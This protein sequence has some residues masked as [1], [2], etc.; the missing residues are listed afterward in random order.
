MQVIMGMFGRRWRRQ[1]SKEKAR[2]RW[3]QLQ[4]EIGAF[5]YEE[6]GFSY[7]F[8]NGASVVRWAEVDRIVGYRL[9][10]MTVDEICIELHIGDRAIR[11]IEST[12]GWY[13]FMKRLKAIFPAIPN[14]WDWDVVKRPFAANYTVLYEREGGDLPSTNNFY[15]SLSRVDLTVV[16]PAFEKAGWTIRK[17]GWEEMEARNNWSEINIVKDRHGV[18]LNGRVAFRAGMMEVLDGVLYGIGSAYQYEVYDEEKQVLREK[19]WP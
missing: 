11:F 6:G 2:L 13:Q 9:D 14:G 7:P 8:E 1:K 16:C 5:D 12:P 19:R 17:A 4:E 18:L 10:L 3:E 15:A